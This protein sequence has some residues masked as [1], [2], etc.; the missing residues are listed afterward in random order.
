M[1]SA[2]SIRDRLKQ[3]AQAKGDDFQV[4]LSRYVVER[5]LFRLSYSK[6]ADR[7]IVKGAS[8]FYVWLPDVSY[9]RVT[10]DLDLLGRGKLSEED[11]RAIVAELCRLDVDDGLV[12]DPGS[13]TTRAI[14]PDDKYGGTRVTVLANLLNI[15][16]LFRSTWAWEIL[17]HLRLFS[18]SSRPCWHRTPPG[19][20]FINVKP[21]LLRSFRLSWNVVCS[22]AG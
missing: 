13:V 18:P 3:L 9:F 22:I 2:S 14:R 16:I 10:R 12:F 11:L 21:L 1:S 17:F 7:F 6:F 4:V 8:L 15:R 5:F 19:F 20:R